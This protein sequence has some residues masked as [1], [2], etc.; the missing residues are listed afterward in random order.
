MSYVME[1]AKDKNS[2]DELIENI[3]IGEGSNV[4]DGSVL[5]T[6]PGCPLKVGKNVTIG[7][8]VMLHGCT[9]GD[10]SLIG[11]GAV[12]LNKA[13]IGKNCIIGA[14]ALITENKVIP[15]NSLVV[16]SPGKVIREVTEEEK[17]RIYILNLDLDLWKLNVIWK[18]SQDKL[19]KVGVRRIQ[20]TLYSSEKNKRLKEFMGYLKSNLEII[21]KKQPV[22]KGLLVKTYLICLK[23]D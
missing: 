17:A 19:V 15:D 4:Q 8:L 23:V 12:I 2:N 5:H 3:H 1:Y 18:K 14:K 20:I 10:N 13:N 22:K 6:D 21:I 16:G 11:I 7:H 9:I